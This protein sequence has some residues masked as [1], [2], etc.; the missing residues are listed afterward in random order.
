MGNLI[1][2]A[3]SYCTLI[4]DKMRTGWTEAKTKT[5]VRY[6]SSNIGQWIKK[7]RCSV[8]YV[9]MFLVFVFFSPFK[10][11]I[12][13]KGF[14]ESF[15]II[16]GFKQFIKQPANE[17]E[18]DS[19]LKP[20]TLICP[21]LERSNHIRGRAASGEITVVIYINNKPEYVIDAKGGYFDCE[22]DGKLNVGDMVSAKQIKDKSKSSTLSPALTVSDNDLKLA[23]IEM[24]KEN[25]K[26]SL[27]ESSTAVL[28]SW[29]ILI[30]GG[31][32]SELLT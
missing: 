28:I 2:K 27:I 21:I 14:I 16:E 19:E 1:E 13:S 15:G 26:I 7:H 23:K 6:L 29:S 17:K 24:D 30:I 18:D 5:F 8:T 20:P 12:Y 10:G 9:G 11:T 32:S 22:V 3:R 25:Q 31:I 4:A